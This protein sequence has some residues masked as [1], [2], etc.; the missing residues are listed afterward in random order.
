MYY[1]LR[2]CKKK[3]QFKKSTKSVNPFRMTIFMS[4][5]RQ[6]HRRNLPEFYVYKDIYIKKTKDTLS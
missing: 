5:H 2:G 1:I 3:V 6:S 4:T